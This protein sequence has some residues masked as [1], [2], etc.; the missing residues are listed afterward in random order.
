MNL[1]DDVNFVTKSLSGDEKMLESAFKLETVYRRHK[2]KIWTLIIVLI[3]FFASRAIMQELHHS[4]LVKANEAFLTL[5]DKSDDTNALKILKEN[6]MALFEAYSYSQAVKNEDAK[7]L[8]TLSKSKNSIISDISSYNEGVIDKKLTDSSVYEDMSLYIDGYLAILAGDT[9]KA[10]NRLGLIDERS[11]L[12]VVSG[13][14]KH[15][16][17]IKEK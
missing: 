17:I 3:A 14:L 6:N 5:Q 9:T 10:K 7:T 2:F 4:K 16:T 1:K 11:P 15:S 12:A 13:F 8:H